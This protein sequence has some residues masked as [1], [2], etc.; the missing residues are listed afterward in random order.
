MTGAG[1]VLTLVLLTW[2]VGSVAAA[3]WTQSWGVVTRGHFRIAAWLVCALAALVVA[4]SWPTISELEGS[5]GIRALVIV[6]TLAAIAHL[7]VQY[8][9]TDG[10]ASFAGYVTAAIG[11]LALIAFGAALESWPLWSSAVG[12]LSG[13]LLWGATT[14]GM[15]LGHW[16]L[17][18]PGLKPW[19]LGR[20]TT[21]GLVAAVAVAVWGAAS[22]SRLLGA[23][24]E[25]AALGLP[26]FGANLGPT[27][28]WSWAALVVL[29]AGVVYMARRCV[30]I[31]SIQSATGLYYVALL[32]AG[33]AEFLG[34]YLMVN[35][36]A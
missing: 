10:I 28:F 22:A 13:A 6:F 23:P 18:Q 30:Q 15:L 3:A 16:Y 7:I 14:N 9:Q 33:V 27:F 2:S 8:G 36:P 35:A 5:G 31:R 29:T 17:N 12:L 4:A 26:G 32:T 21:L 1:A 20:L 19:A 25:G 24:T 34:R 11:A